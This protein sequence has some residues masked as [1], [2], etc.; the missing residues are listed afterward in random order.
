MSKRKKPIKKNDFP[1]NGSY[2]KVLKTYHGK[3]KTQIDKYLIDGKSSTYLQHIGQF[4]NESKLLKEFSLEYLTELSYR[5]SC[6]LITQVTNVD[7]STFRLQTMT[8]EKV[9]EIELEQD[10]EI[11]NLLDNQLDDIAN[12]TQ[13]VDIYDAS[14]NEILFMKDGVCVKKQKA[15]RDKISKEKRERTFTNVMSLELPNNTFETII[16][17]PNIDE[18]TY[19]KA[20]IKYHYKLKEMLPIVVISD[21]ATSIKKDVQAMFG[22][23]VIHILDWYHLDKKIS[24]YLS[25]ISPNKKVKEQDYLMLTNYLWQGDDKKA[26]QYLQSVKSRNDGKK[27]ELLKYLKKNQSYLICYQYRQEIGKTIGSG[28]V[29]KANDLIVAQRQKKN[30]M[31]WSPSGSNNLAIIQAYLYN[32]N[33]SS[34]N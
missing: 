15:I 23:N 16:T 20:R 22:E 26:I 21:G 29:E 34:T 10:L 2:P 1:S 12:R 18:N 19:C 27:E 25:L 8:K 14:F 6:K 11:N 7:L 31:A 3:F 9:S 32:Q 4:D 33:I 13:K 30:G 28:R 17:T 5:K 24:Q